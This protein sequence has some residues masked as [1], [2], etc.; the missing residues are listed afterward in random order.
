VTVPRTEARPPA[1]VAAVALLGPIPWGLGAVL[2]ALL[3]I[4]VVTAG[5]D[6][7][8]MRELS[9]TVAVLTAAVAAVALLLLGLA[10]ALWRGRT[11]AWAASLAVH[12]LIASA[13]GVFLVRTDGSLFLLG[14]PGAWT[15]ASF[16][17]AVLLLTPPVRR[18][19]G[20][21]A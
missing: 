1:A 8:G 4:S 18:W 6:E 15:L 5:A 20:L 10:R 17:A 19:C 11:W 21:P 3:A 13:G 12:A 14:L 2:A 9:A 7:P 16:A